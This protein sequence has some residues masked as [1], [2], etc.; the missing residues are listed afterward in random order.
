[1]SLIYKIKQMKIHGQRSLDIAEK[2][3]FLI[4]SL[5]IGPT[6]DEILRLFHV[7]YTIVFTRRVKRGI[8]LTGQTVPGENIYYICL[9]KF[10][11]TERRKLQHTTYNQLKTMTKIQIKSK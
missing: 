3:K 5:L 10:N 1:M 2:I 9:M 7:K 4:E 6:V 11:P 8:Q